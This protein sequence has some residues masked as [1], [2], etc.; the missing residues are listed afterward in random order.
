MSEDQPKKQTK[1]QMLKE[2]REKERAKLQ[3]D[4]DS[5][6]VD[7]DIPVFDEQEQYGDDGIFITARKQ[8]MDLRLR[9]RSGMK[10]ERAEDVITE[11]PLPGESIHYI[12]NGK[13]DYWTFIPILIRLMDGS[14][15]TYMSTWTMNRSNAMELMDLYDAGKIQ[16]LT[17]ITGDYFKKREA[18][19]YA[20]LITELIKRGQKFKAFMNHAKVTCLSNGHDFLVMEGSANFTSNP[21]IEQTTI[22]NSR[23]LFEFHAGW[24][25]DAFKKANK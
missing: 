10:T 5:L 20:L 15:E 8:K 9:M 24:I 12:T 13:F 4:P 1:Q 16:N 11:I 3:Q 18:V 22:T 19:T 7:F 14:T 25:R 23:E 21:R 2:F 6:A 17:F